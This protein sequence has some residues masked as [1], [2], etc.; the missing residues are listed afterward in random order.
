MKLKKKKKSVRM[1]GTRLHGWAA[2]KHKG[3]G[4][5]GG[6]G[7]A[8]TGKRADQRKTYVLKYDYP[9][10]GKKAAKLKKHKKKKINS[11]NLQQIQGNL[12]SGEKELNFKR[13]KILGRGDIKDKVT[14]IANS[15]S[16]SAIKK[17]EKAGG[18]IIINKR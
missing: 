2:K 1:R 17:V 4:N 12:K 14:I 6:K 11:I 15:A 16:K 5:R 9:Y 10:F 3:S 7:M 18:K 13:Y 8:G